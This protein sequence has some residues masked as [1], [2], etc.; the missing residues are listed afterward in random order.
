MDSTNVFFGRCYNTRLTALT[1][2]KAGTLLAPAL[3]LCGRNNRHTN[4][5][6]PLEVKGRFEVDHIDIVVVGSS[7]IAKGNI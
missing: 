2:E 7:S 1:K 6:T 4:G 5:K 3:I